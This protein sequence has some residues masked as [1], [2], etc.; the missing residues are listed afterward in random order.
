MS[1]DIVIFFSIKPFNCENQ[2]IQTNAVASWRNLNPDAKI[3]LFGKDK[4]SNKLAKQFSLVHIKHVQSN[5][6]GLPF[7]SSMIKNVEK[8]SNSIFAYFNSDI[9]ITEKINDM[10]KPINTL[11]NEKM[12]VIGERTDILLNEP[13]NFEPGW[14]EKIKKNYI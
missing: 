7:I 8:Y 1:K 3:I 9:V 10:L 4:G 5:E 14:N 12:L 13:I 6:E 11:A 2:I